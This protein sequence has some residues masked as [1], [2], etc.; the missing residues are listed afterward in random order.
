[1][2]DIGAMGFVALGVQVVALEEAVLWAIGA[3][4]QVVVRKSGRNG[5]LLLG[6]NVVLR[7]VKI[8]HLLEF[9]R[10]VCKGEVGIK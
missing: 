6:R 3:M 8:K 5:G 2:M 7:R 9:T 1:M 4:E 10:G